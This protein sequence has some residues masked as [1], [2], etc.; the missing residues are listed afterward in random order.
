VVNSQFSHRISGSNLL[1]TVVGTVTNHGKFA[2]KDLGVEAQFLESLIR[3]GTNAS[4][5][6]MGG[7]PPFLV[8]QTDRLP[9]VS[10]T[11]DATTSLQNACLPITSTMAVFR[12][13]SQ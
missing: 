1:V 13:R 10:W 9:A 4:L 8:Q 12:I 6:W 2:W 7:S 11:N 3:A 5:S